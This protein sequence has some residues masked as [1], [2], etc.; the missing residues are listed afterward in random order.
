[1]NPSSKDALGEDVGGA[2]P[3]FN[4]WGD[5]VRFDEV[6]TPDIPARLLPGALGNFAAALAHATE[7]PNAL[8]VMDV[9]GV[10][11]TAVPM[12]FVV[13]PKDGWREPINIYTAAF[14]PP[15]NTKSAVLKA[16]AEPLVQWENEK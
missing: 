5:P 15:G 3:D 14:L 16:C 8:A 7:T 6:D 4:A 9:L 12:R 10:V 1:M 2:A 11:S 13:S